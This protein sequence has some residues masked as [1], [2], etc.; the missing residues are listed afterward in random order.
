MDALRAGVAEATRLYAELLT[1]LGEYLDGASLVLSDN[2]HF[3]DVVDASPDG[4]RTLFERVLSYT[5]VPAD[6]PFSLRFLAADEEGGGC[7]SGACGPK[8]GGAV[9]PLVE[10]GADGVWLVTVPV[11]DAGSPVR[12]MSHLARAAGDLLTLQAE[13]DECAS[14]RERL[15]RAE[16]AATACGLGPQLLAASHVVAKGC[17]GLRVHEG[18]ALPSGVLAALV[19][20]FAECNDEGDKLGRLRR[21]LQP[22]PAEALDDARAFFGKRAGFVAQLRDTPELVA[23]HCDFGPEEGLLQRWFGPKRPQLVP[24]SS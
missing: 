22:T 21:Q 9:L 14:S 7:S 2:E 13:L 3:P 19:V 1:E 15:V 16:I 4:I 12:L 23:F 10:R 11:Q 24:R 20:L 18:T 6:T 17:G 8:G 5:P